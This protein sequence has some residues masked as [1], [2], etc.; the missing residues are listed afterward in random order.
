MSDKTN[1]IPAKD[2]LR[3]R[4]TSLQY[5]VTQN[6]ATERAFTGEYWNSK[7]PGTYRCVV[8]ETELFSSDAKYDSG[9][10]WPSFWEAIDP[11]K[12]T[13]TVDRSHGMI[14][15]EVTCATCGA[16]LG[17]LFPD[18]P[19]PTGERYCMNSASLRLD[20]ADAAT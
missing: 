15:T 7:D 6:A 17:H 10:G 2:D 5:E 11:D 20:P 3:Q 12:V 18:G 1:P 14:R 8:C 13:L 19:Q 4:L 9:S 16:H